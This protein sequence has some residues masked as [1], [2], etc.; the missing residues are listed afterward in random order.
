MKVNDRTTPAFPPS[1]PAIFFC[2]LLLCAATARAE[3]ASAGPETQPAVAAQGLGQRSR[4]TGDWGGS[5]SRMEAA[6]VKLDLELTMFYQGLEAG[7]GSQ[8]YEFGSR[9][10]GFVKLDT[11]KMGLWR[12]GGLVTHLEYRTGDLPGSLGGTFFP[13]N[14]GMEFPSDSPDELVATSVYLSQRLGDQTSLL[15]GK[16]NALDLVENDLFFGGWGNHR[17]MNAVFAAPPSGLVPPVFIGAIGSYRKDAAAVSLWIYDPM[18]R[19]GDYFP[20][21][22]FDNGVT[23]YLTPSY[24][25]KVDGRPT[26]I[27]L[28]GI[29][30]TK[31]GVDFSEL[32]ENYQNALEPSTKEGSYSV[33][34]QLSHLLHVDAANPRKG[35]GVHV[36]GAVSDGNPNY[37]QN[38]IIAGLGG[39]ELIPGRKLDSFGLGYFY[40]DLSDALQDE[41]TPVGDRFSDEQGAEAYYS[42]AVTPWFFVTGDLEYVAPP[43]KSLENAFLVGLRAN[44]RF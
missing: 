3:P 36:K 16:I 4:L 40:Y 23:F 34:F 44:I 24:S 9:L 21:D 31:S 2:G 26:T 37:V 41:L 11:G 18:D 30:T 19:T 42:Y 35:W 22:L 38:S 17:F 15:L 10:D 39:T 12:G 20:G 13:T 43:R 6:G 29:Y 28:T 32:S 33:G 25:A 1:L 14:S 7:T 27:S 8:D 5:R